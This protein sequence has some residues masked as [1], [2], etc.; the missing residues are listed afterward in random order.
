M[1]ILYCNKYNSPFSGTEVYLF[2]LMDLMR[3]HGHDVALFSM[4]DS[5]GT[6]P[7]DQHFVP[8]LDFKVK[9]G[10]LPKARQAAHAIYSTR[11]R[12]KLRAM[13]AD[14]RPDVA[15]IRNIYHHLSPSI[16]WEQKAQGVPVLYHVNDFKLLCPNYNLVSRGDACEACKGGAFWHTMRVQCYPGFGAR[17]TLT[18]EAYVHKWLGTYR[19]CVNLFLAPS[20]FVREKF[21]DHGWDVSKFEVLPHFQ[22]T[23]DIKPFPKNGP[24]LYFGRLSAEKGVDDLLRAMQQLPYLR[25]VVAGDGPQ[26]DELHRLS[27]SLGLNNVEFVGHVGAEERDRLIAQSRFTLLPSHAYETL[28]KTILESYAEG[29]GRHCLRH[30]LTARIGSSGRDR[31]PVSIREC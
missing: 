25:L 30:W 29:A 20:R 28:G 10:L 21:V 15:H 17:A 6:T 31:D 2:E 12:R 9:A 18:L 24:L 4:A 5:R 8:N 3:A 1:R 16:L 14:F 7:Y 23:H 13:I 11:A 26:R 19:K 27:V 22:K